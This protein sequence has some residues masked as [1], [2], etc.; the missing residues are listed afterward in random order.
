MLYVIADLHLSTAAGMNK[1]MDVFGRRW[2]GYVEKLK[3]NWCAVIGEDDSVVIPGDVSW[4]LSLPEAVDD[5]RLIDALPGHKFLGKGNHDYWWSTASKMEGLFEANGFRTLSLLH[6]NAYVCED[7]ILCGTRGWYQD[8]CCENMPDGTDFD[9]L[10]AREA[11]RLRLSLEE[12]RRLTADNPGKETLVFLHFPPTWNGLRCQPILSL[13]EEYG[14]RR[15]YFGHIHGNYTAPASFTE[16]G[17][18]YSLISADFLN[19]CPR[20]ILPETLLE[21]IP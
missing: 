16:N 1:S 20:P 6:N 4:A 12:G 7:F 11:I 5:L 2:N 19:F 13:L 18:R 17:I 15:C 21:E 14:V 9:K 10:V 8:A 3:K